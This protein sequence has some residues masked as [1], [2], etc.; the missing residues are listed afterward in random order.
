MLKTRFYHLQ[1]LR[2]HHAVKPDD[3]GVVQ[4]LHGGHLLEKVRQ[5]VRLSGHAVP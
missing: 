2:E 3:V 1:G 4:R 5:R